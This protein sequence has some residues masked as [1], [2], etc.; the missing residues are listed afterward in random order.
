MDS[1]V[2][3]M[4]VRDEIS[5]AYVSNALIPRQQVMHWIERGDLRE[6]G[7]LYALTRDAHG[8]IVPP[9][10][11][12]TTGSFLLRY[13]LRCIIENPQPADDV[14]SRFEAAWELTR[15]LDHLWGLR[16]ASDNV[17]ELLIERVTASYLEGDAEIRNVIETGFLE[18][19]LERADFV[20]LFEQWRHDPRLARAYQDC[21]AW[22]LAHRRT[23]PG[24][25]GEEI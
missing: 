12:A 3:D 4:S 15:W 6:W 24:A 1:G 19:A 20:P 10:D 23:D 13:Y 16:P 25:N 7:L 14:H 5:E 22:G 8:R 2:D 17:I 21:L 9:L 11:L 18:H